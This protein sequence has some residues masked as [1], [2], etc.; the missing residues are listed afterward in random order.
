MKDKIIIIETK[1]EDDFWTI[2]FVSLT[3]LSMSFTLGL[4]AGLTSIGYF[5]VASILVIILTSSVIA[6]TTHEERTIELEKEVE[7]K[8]IKNGGRG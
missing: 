6:T 3:I 4:I 5:I 7:I 1:K 8:E 2:F